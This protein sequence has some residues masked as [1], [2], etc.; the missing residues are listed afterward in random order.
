[1]VDKKE[2]IVLISRKSN[3][4]YYYNVGTGDY[5]CKEGFLKEEDLMDVNLSSIRSNLDVEFIKFPASNYDYSN[6]IRR[7]PQIITNKD[8]GYIIA[9][10]RINKNSVIVEAGGGS[11]GATIFFAS[12]VKEVR[13][14]EIVENHYN[15]IKSNLTK[16]NI[17]NVKLIHGDLKENIGSESNF[18]LLFLDMPDP[19]IIL[20]EDLDGLKKGHYIVSYLPSISQII[21]LFNFIREREDLYL[22]EV[23][24]V[25]LRY[26]KVNSKISRPEHRKEIDHTAFLVFIRKI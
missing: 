20:E 15:I 21:D 3:R 9:R 22:E 11:G 8:L 7:G 13:T 19:K 16:L 5:H 2:M 17:D 10:T 18:D 26:W 6:K 14:Y 12:I 1:M 4:V 23:S 25:I 24:E